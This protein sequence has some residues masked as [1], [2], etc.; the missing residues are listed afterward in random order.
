M[1]RFKGELGLDPPL[2]L[3]GRF[4][5]GTIPDGDMDPLISLC[6]RRQ[7]E[8]YKSLSSSKEERRLNKIKEK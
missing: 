5:L 7:R 1:A 6:H 8:I 4:A 2:L 3:L